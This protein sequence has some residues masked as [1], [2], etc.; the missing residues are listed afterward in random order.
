MTDNE[1]IATFMDWKQ[2]DGADGVY[3]KGQWY[4]DKFEYLALGAEFEYNTSWDWL[5]PVVSKIKW[6]LDESPVY[7]AYEDASLHNDITTIRIFAPI[8]KVYSAAVEFIKWY[9]QQK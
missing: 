1:L 2:S 4:N 9:N 8:D 6:L 7:L 3:H 5:M